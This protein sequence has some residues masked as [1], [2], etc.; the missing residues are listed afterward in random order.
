MDYDDPTFTHVQ[1]IEMDNDREVSEPI[2]VMHMPLV[3]PS[4]VFDL[5]LA[6]LAET[7]LQPDLFLITR[8]PI[9]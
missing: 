6:I 5:K 4:F 2:L 3:R 7:Y 1:H 9:A 8:P